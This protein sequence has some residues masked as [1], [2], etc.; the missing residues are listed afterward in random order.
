MHLCYAI[1]H[2]LLASLLRDC[3]PRDDHCHLLPAQLADL[4]RGAGSVIP[5]ERFLKTRSD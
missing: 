3:F 5:D 2:I 1:W 4:L